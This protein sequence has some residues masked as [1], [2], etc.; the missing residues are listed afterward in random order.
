MN[1]TKRLTRFA[2]LTALALVLSWL[3]A[4]LPVFFAVPGMKLG[5][6]NLAALTALYLLGCKEALIVNLLRVALSALLFGSVVSLWYSLAGALLSFAVMALLKKSGRFSQT[7]VS[8]AGGVSHNM[9]QL[10]A[11]MALL[12]TASL[13]WYLPLLWFAGLAAGAGIGL[14]GSLLCRLLTSHGWGADT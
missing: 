13:G 14:V 11:A 8:L 10:L 9:G 4:Q 5:L 1:K 7:V 2:L 3:E 6:A 12:Q